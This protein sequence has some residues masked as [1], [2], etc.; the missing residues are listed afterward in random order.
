[1]NIYRHS[2][3]RRDMNSPFSSRRP[4]S[5]S[6]PLSAVRRRFPGETPPTSVLF[7]RL[8]HFTRCRRRPRPRPTPTFPSH[9]EGFHRGITTSLPPPS[10]VS[11]PEAPA[12]PSTQ[13]TLVTTRTLRSSLASALR[14]RRR[15]RQYRLRPLD[16][17]PSAAGAGLSALILQGLHRLY[18][19][20]QPHRLRYF[21]V[22]PEPSSLWRRLAGGLAMSCRSVAQCTF[23]QIPVN[24]ALRRPRQCGGRLFL[25]LPAT[26][27]TV[28]TL[29][30]TL[31][32]V[33]TPRPA[34]NA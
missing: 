21:C 24:N 1:M 28:T 29:P 34:L 16:V 2:H 18:P 23:G 10:S 22:V 3:Q 12:F 7:R 11:G 14:L 15:W 5:V 20:R 6:N 4:R 19:D 17:Q 26:S 33:E 30:P 8:L 32:R 25:P 27:V 9:A 13:A 31:G